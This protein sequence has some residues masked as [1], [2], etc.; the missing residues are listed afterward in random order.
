[1]PRPFLGIRSLMLSQRFRNTGTSLPE[2]L[3]ETG[4]LG[5][6]TMPDSIASMREKSHTVQGNKVPS[7]YPEPWRKKG[8]AERS[9]TARV[10]I[11]L[12]TVPSR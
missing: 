9:I 2:V 11:F 4:T 1:M 12:S 6:L 3:S 8:V 10:P 7:W 5:I